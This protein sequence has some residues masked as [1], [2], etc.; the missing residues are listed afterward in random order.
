MHQRKDLRLTILM[1]LAMLTWG[2]S[3]T[4]AKILGQYGNASLIM[5]WRFIFATLSFALVLK[6]Y[7]SEYKISKK[8]ILFILGNAFFMVSYNYFYFRGTQIGLAGSGGVLVT[9]LN[10]ILTSLFSSLFFGGLILKKDWIGFGLGLIGGT[11]I[12]RLW[13]FN[14]YS[15]LQSGNIF[16]ILASLSWVSVT[17]IT[18]QSKNIIPFIPYTFW[19]F[20]FASCLCL[21]LSLQESLLSVFYFDWIFWLNLLILAVVAMSFGTSIYF[22]ASVQ[23]GPKRAS[24]FIFIVPLTAMGFAIYFLSEPFQ[25]TTAIGGTL[26]IA[27][28]YIINH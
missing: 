14:L 4:N 6:W 9:T 23:L 17:I 5:F 2:L 18:S 3:W 26:G 7:G 16:F 28:V 12:L 10:P 22:L 21:P 19:S 8:N 13:D 20:V 15:L 25:L 11:I 27:A 1:V 24:A